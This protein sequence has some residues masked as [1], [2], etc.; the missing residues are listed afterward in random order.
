MNITPLGAIWLNVCINSF[1]PIFGYLAAGRVSP[2]LFAFL[3]SALGFATFIPWIIKNK[4]LREYF[5]PE[6]ALSLLGIG[7]FGSALPIIGLI[8]ALKYTTP[9][10]AAIIGQIEAI[11]SIIL[12]SIFLREKICARQLAGTALVL[13]GTMLIVF[14]ERFTF[15]WTGDLI[16]MAIPLSYQISHLISKKLPKGISHIFVASARTLYA[17][18]GILPLFAAGFFTPVFHFQPELKTFAIV[19]VWGVILTALNNIL[20]YKA[21]LN[22]DL[23]K[24][25][26]IVL[27][28]PVLTALLSAAFGMEKIQAYQMAGLA[29]A[30]AGAY[31]VTLLARKQQRI[32]IRDRLPAAVL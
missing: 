19:A 28:Y 32:A 11:Y 8:I 17:A 1:I 23:S 12:S 20:W 7:F 24:A 29:L 3:G 10:N 18:L 25:T 26:A 21:I 9:A 27:S 13:A 15:R 31:W 5:R 2:V 16:V 30:L 4:V 6:L 22:M 14:K